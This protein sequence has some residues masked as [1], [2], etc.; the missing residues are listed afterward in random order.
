MN[1][2]AEKLEL[3]RMILDTDNPSILSSIKR[4]FESYKNI[5][6]WDSLPESQKE[7]ILRGIEEVENGE[8]VDYEEFMKK[9]R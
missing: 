3:V 7:E 9:H 5:D 6:F 2:Q 1:I 8:T 4:I